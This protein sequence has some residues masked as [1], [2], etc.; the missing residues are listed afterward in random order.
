MCATG[1][2]SFVLAA[3]D[4]AMGVGAVSVEVFSRIRLQRCCFR[5]T[6]N[7]LKADSNRNSAQ[8]EPACAVWQ[9]A[10]REDALSAFHRFVEIYSVKYST[11]AEKLKGLRRTTRLVDLPAKLAAPANHK[12][13]RV[14]VHD[15]TA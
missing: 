12:P 7:V 14:D 8:W 5:K 11:A 6:G 13:Y 2:G 4:G 1:Y 3:G 15:G 9:P 10:T